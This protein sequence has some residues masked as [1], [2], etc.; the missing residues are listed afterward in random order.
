MHS[1]C[2]GLRQ[3]IRISHS[4]DDDDDDSCTRNF[5]DARLSKE[6]IQEVEYYQDDPVMDSLA[7]FFCCALSPPDETVAKEAPEAGGQLKLGP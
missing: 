5:E 7:V 4:F 2:L 6:I 1:P 3:G